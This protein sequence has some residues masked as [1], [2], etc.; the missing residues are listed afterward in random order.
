MRLF[1][2]GGWIDLS[3]RTKLRLTGTDRVRY[4]NGQA[5]N[6]VRRAVGGEAMFACVMTA[7]G[8]MCADIFIHA[9]AEALL[10]DA[11]P[12]LREE[13]AAR[14]ERYIIADDVTLTDV[15]DDLALF[16]FIAP[17]TAPAAV[18]DQM[19]ASQRYGRPGFDAILPASRR[20]ALR[21]ACGEGE[22]RS[23]NVELL[24]IS[25]RIPRWG[26]DLAADTIPVEAG[27]EERAISYTKG[28]YI[29]QEV[30]SRIKS[31]GQ[32][33]HHLV[34]LRSPALPIAGER[35]LAGAADIGEITSVAP[36]PDGSGSIALAY[37]R[38]G[39]ESAGN[40]LRSTGGIDCEV[41]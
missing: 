2:T 32:V 36:L 18:R 23:A 19:I 26:P 22:L 35:L 15:T 34:R 25:E 13:L 6:D 37:V 12:E 10:I 27:L 17:A 11:E 3:S 21:E 30:I 9:E 14:L 33:N 39:Q 1:P 29:G 41:W 20:A 38:R 24:R 5:S 40:Q 28:C 31:I 8:K 16:H 4:L 7:K